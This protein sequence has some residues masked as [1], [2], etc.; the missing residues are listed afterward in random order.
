MTETGTTRA[1]AAGR[2]VSPSVWTLFPDFRGCDR[3]GSGERVHGTALHAVNFPVMLETS[4]NEKFKKCSPEH[5]HCKKT[6]IHQAGRKDRLSPGIPCTQK[7]VECLVDY[8]AAPHADK[9]RT[10]H[11]LGHL[12]RD[13]G[14][15]AEYA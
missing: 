1:A 10:G 15:G 6:Q 7:C 3:G 13:L 11:L 12:P 14:G 9:E 4:Q 2:K 8:L 5:T